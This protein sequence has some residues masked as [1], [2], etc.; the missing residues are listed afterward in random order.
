VEMEGQGGGHG[1]GEGRRGAG[2]G[3]WGVGGGR[4]WLGGRGG[5]W[6]GRGRGWGARRW[7]VLVK[8][9]GAGEGVV[10]DWRLERQ[11]GGGQRLRARFRG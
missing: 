10:G 8:G 6:G 7:K 1:I 4:W 9:G 11:W 2:G 3:R 5:I